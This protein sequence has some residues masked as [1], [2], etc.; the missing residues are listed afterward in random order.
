[1]Y[2]QGLRPLS[3]SYQT[4]HGLP[5]LE[6]HMA[7]VVSGWWAEGVQG[8]D[9]DGNDEEFPLAWMAAV[10]YVTFVGFTRFVQSRVKF[11]CTDLAFVAWHVF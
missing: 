5:S 10:G 3:D 1:M 7:M 6:T 4:S 2:D 8:H 11:I 9:A